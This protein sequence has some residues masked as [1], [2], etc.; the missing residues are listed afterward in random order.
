MKKITFL[1]LVNLLI[2]IQ[3][4]SQNKHLKHLASFVSKGKESAETVAYDKVSKRA[5]ITNSKANSFSIVNITTPSSP[6]LVK[7]VDLSSYGAG[8]NSIAVHNGNVA[9]AIESAVKQNNGKVTFFDVDGTFV[10]EFTVGAL[11]DM[12]TFTPNGNKLLVANEGEPND[13]YTNDPEGSVSIID[14]TSGVVTGI[15]STISFTSY[16]DKKE[17]LLNK[18]VRI[19]GKNATVAQDLEPE[20]ITVTK[21][22]KYAYVNCQENNA[23]VVIDLSDN[24]VKDIL[25]LGYKN[26]SLGTP[27]VKLISINEEA[28]NWPDLGTPVYDGGQPSVKLGGFSGLWHD[29]NASTTNSLVFYA[30]P[31]RG[32]NASPVK[33]AKVTPAVPQNLR[34]FKL[35][36]YQ[37]RIAKFTV[38]PVTGSTTLDSQILLTRKD[39]TTPITG[40]GNIPG[41]D[42]IPVT[43]ADANTAYPKE[44]YKDDKNETYH[45][46]EYD[47][48]GGDFEGILIDKNGKFWMCDEYRPALYKFEPNGKLIER[49]VP[50]GTSQL[51]TVSKPVGTY[52][53]ETLPAVYN[54]RRANRGFEAIAYDQV[55]D[56]VYAF[57]QSPMYNPSSATKNKS[58]IIRILGVKATDGTPVAEYVYVL[59]RNKD[60]GH[61]LSRVDK[62]GDAFFAG[63]GRIFVL[64]RDSSKPTDKGGKK[65]V[66]SININ[67]ATNVLGK[68]YTKELEEM[69]TDELVAEG[70]KP[71]TKFK[72]FNLPSIGYVSSDKAEGLVFLPD[73][74]MAVLNDNDFGLAGAGITDKSVLGIISTAS[75]YGF[76]ASDK[77]GKID[78][79]AQETLGMYQPDAIASYNVDGMDYIVT[80][81]EGDSRDYTGYSE[82][83]RVAKLILDNNAYP[84]A[85]D[86]QKEEN[87]GRLKTTKANGDYNGDGKYEQIYSYGT[88]SFSIF[89]KYGNL[90]FDSA[91]IFGQKT[92]EEEPGLFNQHK[93][94]KDGRSD[95][96][97][98]EPEAV[99]IGTID[100]KTYAFIGLERQSSLLVFDIT[101]PRDVKF[102]TYYKDNVMH[103]D[104]APEVIKFISS[105]DSPNGKDMI[106]VGYEVSG[107]MAII[108][109]DKIALSNAF[110]ETSK[111]SF[112]A[113]PVPVSSVLNFNKNI[114]AI[115][116]SVNGKLVKRVQNNKSVDVSDLAE[117]VYIVKTKKYGTRR[118]LKM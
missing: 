18:G 45:A 89:D 115:I 101:N 27:S 10:K 30:V 2:T 90:V 21:D 71:V 51:G 20:Y 37:G 22:E 77:D 62:I 69:T 35:P 1:L 72:M 114:D 7:E 55:N 86:L 96:K 28:T 14:I 61:A 108:E 67:Y 54:K 100:G 40:K 92:Q 58:D 25:P 26:H 53:A 82:E 52:G 44:D 88:R 11:P 3:V 43:Y 106:L 8:P 103:N 66:Y 29:R 110:V 102:V 95:D 74:K 117:G 68:S 24:S 6:V 5:F 98:V 48:Y 70:I 49:Y 76:D 17:S 57:I 116:Y 36:N 85:T 109:I 13:D 91:D 38:N 64:E 111:E 81:N 113:Y 65:Y 34:P 39:G 79:K 60:K 107:T 75:N 9:I 12:I 112:I 32:P 83:T 94:K 87:L 84:N 47:A 56:I 105:A 93:G 16:N 19:F 78:I 97:G 33:K 42:E 46:L 15:V 59:E 4:S 80:A 50:S 31:D 63:K 23:F 41:F 73:G 99:A 118:F 104:V